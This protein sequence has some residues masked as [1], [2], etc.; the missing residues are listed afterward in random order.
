M[1][2]T[3]KGVVP[4]SVLNFI[5]KDRLAFVFLKVRACCAKDGKLT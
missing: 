3:F 1:Y 2:N 5:Y 4:R